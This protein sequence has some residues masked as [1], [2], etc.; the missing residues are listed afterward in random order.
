MERNLCE[1]TNEVVFHLNLRLCN[2][3]HLF[4]ITVLLSN[5]SWITKNADFFCNLE[6]FSSL[7][8]IVNI[9]YV[10]QFCSIVSNQYN[11]ILIGFWFFSFFYVY[12]RIYHDKKIALYDILLEIYEC[13]KIGGWKKAIKRYGMWRWRF[14]LDYIWML[15]ITKSYD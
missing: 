11:I 8:N 15:I 4:L 12:A 14:V 9:Q 10:W 6:F 5:S 7:S 13:K 2:N 3:T 1:V